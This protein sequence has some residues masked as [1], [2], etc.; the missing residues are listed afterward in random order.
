MGFHCD[1]CKDASP[2]S[3]PLVPCPACGGVVWINDD[4]PDHPNAGSQGEPS[5]EDGER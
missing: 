1:N 4:A 3:P 2:D 5:L